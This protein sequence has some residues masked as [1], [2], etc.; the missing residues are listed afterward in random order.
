MQLPDDVI[1]QVERRLDVRLDYS[2]PRTGAWATSA[3]HRGPWVRVDSRSPT[4]I[5]PQSWVGAEAAS[6]IPS[7]PKPVWFQSATWLDTSRERVWRAEEMELITEPVV[8]ATGTM[9]TAARADLVDRVARRPGGAGWIPDPAGRRPLRTDH[10][11]D[12]SGARRRGGHH[13]HR[14]DHLAR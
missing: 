2:S 5:Q 14:M 12:Q 6:V 13:R 9:L 10:P 8:T 11:P 7:I 3:G 4:V 1:A